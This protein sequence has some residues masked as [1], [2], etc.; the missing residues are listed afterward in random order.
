MYYTNFGW[1]GGWV[2]KRKIIANE[3]VERALQSS[4]KRPT[5]SHEKISESNGV[6]KRFFLYK[7]TV[8]I[9]FLFTLFCFFVGWLALLSYNDIRRFVPIHFFFF[10]SYFSDPTEAGNCKNTLIAV[11][12]FRYKIPRPRD[13]DS[14]GIAIWQRLKVEARRFCLILLPHSTPLR[15]RNFSLYYFQV[16][17]PQKRVSSLL[18]KALR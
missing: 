1:V 6:Q 7:Y 11:F 8:Y 13:Y 3:S 16:R 10:F 2:G 12:F 5:Q 14:S 9:L 18:V 17:C 15:P 4:H